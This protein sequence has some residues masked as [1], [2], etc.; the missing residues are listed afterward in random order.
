MNFLV[1]TKHPRLNEAVGLILFTLTV[2]VLLSLVSSHPT[3]P[4]FNVSRN[5]LSDSSVQNFIASF[6]STL[7]YLLLQVLGYPASLLPIIYSIFGWNWIS[8][9]QIE[10]QWDKCLGM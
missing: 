3:D 10:N 2:L 6:G 4:S 7:A 8:S 1:P 9:R 5:S